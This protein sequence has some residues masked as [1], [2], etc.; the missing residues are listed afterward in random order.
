[1]SRQLVE[2][3]GDLAAVDQQIVGPLDAGPDLRR[4][5]DC[6]A[7]RDGK[8]QEMDCSGLMATCIQH[9]IDHLN[10][11]LFI[12]QNVPDM[13]EQSRSTLEPLRDLPFESL[14]PGSDELR[15]LQAGMK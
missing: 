8:Q 7:R 4:P 9:E 2:Q 13:H 10:G 12:D 3:T 15:K 6:I 5:G 1:M 14:C 11:V